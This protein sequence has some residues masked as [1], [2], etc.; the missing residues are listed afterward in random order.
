MSF[1]VGDHVYVDYTSTDA[2]GRTEMYP[3]E[4]EVMAVRP[5][6]WLTIRYPEKRTLYNIDPEH[7]RAFGEQNEKPLPA[8][9]LPTSNLPEKAVVMTDE[10]KAQ[11]ERI[12]DERIV[13]LLT[14]SA[15]KEII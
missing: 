1:R 13:E 14:S 2:L 3:G 7:V 5:D 10:L 9:V 6:G 4:A 11:I 12:V 15:T 8:K